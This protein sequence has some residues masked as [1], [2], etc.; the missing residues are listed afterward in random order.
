VK[1]AVVFDIE[2]VPLPVEELLATAP[3]FK[4][5][6]NLKDPA[7]IAAAKEE[8]RAAYIERAALDWKTAQV[9]LVG[10]HDGREYSSFTGLE[11]DVIG[12]SLALIGR[13]LNQGTSVG[14]HNVKAFDL[15]MLINRARLLGAPIPDGIMA[16]YR[17]R[18]GW[19]EGIFDTLEVLSFGRSFEGNGCDDCARAFGLPAKLGSGADFPALWRADRDGAINY[20]RRDCEIEIQLAQRCGF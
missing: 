7:K 20:N 6:A 13:L 5:P 18:F 19:H 4:A 2:T 14:G 8:K 12:G 1:A 16:W 11:S 3:E 15:P 10:F 9:V 17:G